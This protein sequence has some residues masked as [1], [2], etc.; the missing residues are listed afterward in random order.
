[1]GN[2]VHLHICYPAPSIFGEN[3]LFHV[4]DGDAKWKVVV[5]EE[6]MEATAFPP[7][8]SR[9]RLVRYIEFYRAI[10]QAAIARNADCNGM[11]MI[12]EKDILSAGHAVVM[13]ADQ[14]SDHLRVAAH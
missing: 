10:A 3:G 1:M 6:A 11:V 8:A 12:F 7:D 13:P 4:S 5:T 9:K 2:P 14:A